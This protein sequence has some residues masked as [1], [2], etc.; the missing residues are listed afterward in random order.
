MPKH[1][2]LL[3]EAPLSPIEAAL[4]SRGYQVTPVQRGQNLAQ[5]LL[6]LQ[7]DVVFVGVASDGGVLQGQ[8]ES[9]GIPYTHSGVLASALSQHRHQRKIILRSAG[10]P[11][12]DHVV[13]HLMEAGKGHVL[14]APYVIKPLS[15]RPTA[16]L[17][18]AGAPPMQFP[19]LS[20]HYPGMDHLIVERYL[21]GV[22]LVCTVQGG[23]ALG[24]AVVP[25]PLE[26]LPSPMGTGAISSNIYDK[27]Q[28]MGLKA[29]EALGCRGVVE[30]K[31][32]YN[33]QT[34]SDSELV[35]V[36]VDTQPDLMPAASLARQVF[37]SGQSYEQL[38]GWIVEDAS[39]NR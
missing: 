28:K 37:A 17:V 11:V 21:P 20:A 30:V 23:V 4:R 5:R 24:A 7:P 27:A 2:A 29:H 16:I 39:C 25:R 12:T 35:W 31:F 6:E 36:S 10:V 22:D 34:G 1:V 33:D 32:R 3:E 19:E 18:K 8:L 38:I 26:T 9:L 13:V 14:P 15:G